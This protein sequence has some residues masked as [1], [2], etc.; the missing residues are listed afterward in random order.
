MFRLVPNT[1]SFGHIF[2]DAQAGSRYIDNI[3]ARVDLQ[4]EAYGKEANVP[5]RLFEILNEQR[6]RLMELK[7]KYGAIVTPSQLMA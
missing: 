5:A 4:K 7:E 1:I 6:E 3:V 2:V